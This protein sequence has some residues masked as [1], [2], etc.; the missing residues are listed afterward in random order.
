MLRAILVAGLHFLTDRNSRKNYQ[1]RSEH[2]AEYR[3]THACIPFPS[4]SSL[5]TTPQ[6]G[7][8]GHLPWY[9]I[10]RSEA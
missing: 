2:C 4:V 1:G 6:T 7:H 3:M 5:R 8:L 9:R 10:K